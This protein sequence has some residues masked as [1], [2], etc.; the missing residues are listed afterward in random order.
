MWAS[1]GPVVGRGRSRRVASRCR[2][3]AT[4]ARQ[5]S[6]A[7]ALEWTGRARPGVGGAAL[8]DG[9]AVDGD[10]D[11]GAGEGAVGERHVGW[12]FWWRGVGCRVGHWAVSSGRCGGS[13]GASAG[14]GGGG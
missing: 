2:A 9:F 12:G 10:V 11:E 13:V 7:R 3:A 1:S 6:R 4:V 14:G 8:A 5:G